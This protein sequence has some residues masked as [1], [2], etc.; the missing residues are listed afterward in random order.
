M[1][2]ASAPEGGL[3]AV[4]AAAGESGRLEL[5][6]LPGLPMVKQGDDLA[7]LIILV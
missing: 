3:R 7:G 4:P 5:I 1:S 2:I 6:A